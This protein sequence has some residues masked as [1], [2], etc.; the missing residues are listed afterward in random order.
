MELKYALVHEWLTPLATGG[1][2][3][4]VQE[5]LQWIDA[6]LFA[7]IDFESTNPQSYLYQ[8]AIGTTFLQHFYF[9]NTLGWVLYFNG[10]SNRWRSSWIQK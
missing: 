8:R 6:D 2:E 7:L 5:I 9:G 3:L 4:V 1:S 10:N